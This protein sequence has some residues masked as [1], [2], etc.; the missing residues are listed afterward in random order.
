MA[1]EIDKKRLRTL[2]IT[3]GLLLGVALALLNIAS[4]YIMLSAT[5]VVLI[6]AVP[7]IFSVL[8]PILLVVVL[9]FNFRKKIGG[10]WTL[11]EAATGIFIM[12]FT[13]FVVLFILRDQLFAKV[14]EP[15]MIEKTQLAMTNSVSKFLKESKTSQ[16]VINKKLNEIQQEFEAQK[17]VTIGKQI[18]GVGISIIFMFVLAIIFAAFFKKEIQVYNPQ[19]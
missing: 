15:H 4:F 1:I 3:F 5:S 11:R 10:F 7:F 14:I 16:D 12:F 17:D 19:T 13:A 18:Q 8:L 6:S 9:C 2:G